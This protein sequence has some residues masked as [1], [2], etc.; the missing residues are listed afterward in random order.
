M[1]LGTFMVILYV[2]AAW[3]GIG[4]MA[5]LFLGHFIVIGRAASRSRADEDEAVRRGELDVTG[6]GYSRRSGS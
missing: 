1:K 3:T 2:I 5:S 6:H 4:V